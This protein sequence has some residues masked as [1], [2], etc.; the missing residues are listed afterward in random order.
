MSARRRWL[1]GATTFALAWSG[2]AASAAEERGI[3]PNQGESLV[4]V[5]L[6][7]KAAA[8]RLQLEAETYGVDF[9][10]HYL[11]RNSDGSVTATVFGT[12]DEIAAL[13]AA[14][15]ELGVTI[16]G[17]SSWREPPRASARP[18]CARSGART[19]PRS[20]IPSS[21]RRRTRT[22]SSSCA[23]T[24]SRTTPAASCPSR[25]RTATAARRPTGAT[26]VGPT[27]SLSWNRGAGTPIDSRPRMMNVNIDPDTTPDTYIEH[28]ELLR[29][30]DAG[31]S[32]P[33]RPTRIRIG[34]STGATIEAPV[35]TWL[36]GGLPPM[37][38]RFLKDFTTRYMDPTEV[39][40]RFREL[41]TEFP[42]IAAADP[43]AERDQRL[44]APRTGADGR[45]DG[46][47]QRLPEH[48]G[49]RRRRRRTPSSSPRARGGTRAATTSPP[50]S[51]TPASR[52]R[53]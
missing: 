19:P 20:T 23:S 6:P 39:Y 44:P 29:I 18:T 7:S 43:A 11:R 31:T 32:T 38:S 30:G 8:V 33:P 2:A 4:E 25:P 36:G 51:S 52:T 34:S 47:R 15:F 37:S 40:G 5:Q 1:A 13:D 14:G 53:R 28:R 24:T 27:L 9:N 50:S 48:P 42:N 45:H 10:E 41:A 46:P 12:D 35:N 26:Y 49:R 16:E 21:R 22:R 3:D 17:R